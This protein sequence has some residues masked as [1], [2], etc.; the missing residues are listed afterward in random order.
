MLSMIKHVAEAADTKLKPLLLS[1]NE[2]AALR[3]ATFPLPP[4][5]HP[6]PTLAIRLVGF[7]C[8]YCLANKSVKSVG[9]YFVMSSDR[10][11]RHVSPK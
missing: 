9:E 8:G 6:V 3:A 2:R 7:P 1:L 5:Y 11:G 10:P 4:R